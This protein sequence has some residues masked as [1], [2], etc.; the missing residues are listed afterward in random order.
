MPGDPRERARVHLQN[1]TCARRTQALQACSAVCS[2]LIQTLHSP[3][4][5]LSYRYHYRTKNLDFL[6][7]A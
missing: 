1:G 2:I 6:N 7:S 3:S 5:P 4:P